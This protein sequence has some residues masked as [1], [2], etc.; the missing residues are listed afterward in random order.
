V[1]LTA[2]ARHRRRAASAGG[3]AGNERLTAMTGFALLVLFAAEGVT[4]LRVHQLLTM[5]FFVGML[6]VGPVALKVGSTGYRFVRYYTGAAPY[7]R[8]GPPAPLMR[9]LGPLVMGT[10]LAVLGTGVALAVV[11]PGNSQWIF[12]H[13][14]SFV[15]WFGVMAIHVLVYAPR[16]PWL[17]LGGQPPARAGIGRTGIDRTGIDRTGIDRTG[18]DRTGIDRTGIDRTGFERMGAVLGGRAAR[19]LLLAASL[20]CGLLLAAATLH[21]KTRWGLGI[22]IGG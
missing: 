9:L 16:L 20:A 7:L 2:K 1:S 3:A 4:L 22:G 15:L 13:K 11:G 12:L 5:H 17:L 8:K 14:A 6:L 18:I 21:L 19:W 10:S